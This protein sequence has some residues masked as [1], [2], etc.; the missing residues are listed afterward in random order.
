[1]S[2]SRN[3]TK[4]V[5][6]GIANFSSEGV[7]SGIISDPAFNNMFVATKGDNTMQATVTAVYEVGTISVN[8]NSQTRPAN[9]LS[10]H[11]LPF[12]RNIRVDIWRAARPTV[13]GHHWCHRDD[14]RGDY[15]SD[16]DA[17]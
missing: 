12:W 16:C 15:P 17:T 14:Y 8:F 7:M 9:K 4:T 13:D 11:R 6:R 1:M 5:A 2:D 3:R 10:A